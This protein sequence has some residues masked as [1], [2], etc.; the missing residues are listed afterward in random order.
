[1]PVHDVLGLYGVPVALG[2]LALAG[3]RDDVGDA[4]RFCGEVKT[5]SEA[6]VNPTLERLEDVDATLELYRDVGAV[7]P[8]DI[9]PHW[10]ALI[11][12]LETASTV[13]PADAESLQRVYA[14]AYATE[15][16]A[17]T[18][19]NWL[20]DHCEVDLGPVATIVPPAP[21]KPPATTVP[22]G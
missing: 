17:K 19:R 14:R 2:L 7:A 6:I 13:D 21:K 4:E 15:R 8:L 16:E 9:E 3:C 20:I 18:V 10:D 5:N 11:V 12:N 1:V 22:G